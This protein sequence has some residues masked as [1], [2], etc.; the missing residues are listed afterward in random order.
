MGANAGNTLITWEG[1]EAT[2][3]FAQGAAFTGASDVHIRGSLHNMLGFSGNKRSEVRFSGVMPRHYTL[4]AVTFLW[5]F[6]MGTATSGATV[7]WAAQ[8]RRIGGG[9][10]MQGYQYAIPPSH[11]VSGGFI[12]ASI[13]LPQAMW[14]GEYF[15]IDLLYDPDNPNHTSQGEGEV[16]GAELRES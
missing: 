6:T 3:R 10:S 2:R 9:L 7:W 14:P 16:L 4:G 11:P 13:N 12:L 8:G 1:Y 5:W 15:Q